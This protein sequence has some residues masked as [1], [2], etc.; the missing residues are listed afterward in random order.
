MI[1]VI[2]MCYM[3]LQYQ[4]DARQTHPYIVQVLATGFDLVG[5][6]QALLHESL[7]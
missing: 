2:P 6:H 5:H 4:K 1:E 7:L 3:L